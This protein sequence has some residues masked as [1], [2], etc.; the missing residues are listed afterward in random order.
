MINFSV[1]IPAY[2]EE[3][4][5]AS[6]LSNLKEFLKKKFPQQNYEIIVIND[7]STD[8]TEEIIRGIADVKLINHPCN[9]GYGASIKTGILQSKYDIICIMDADGTY[10]A[11]E[12]KQLL[13]YL[14]EYDMAIGARK[15]ED[16]KMS[17]LRRFAKFFLVIL[18]NV[19]TG[20]KIPDINSGLRVFKKSLFKKYIHLLPEG[21]SLTTTITI[22]A[23]TN[24]H[25][26][27]YININYFSRK[28]KSKIRPIRDTYNFI[29]IIL[30]TLL[31][32]NPLK[33][34]L[35]VGIF[36]VFLAIIIGGW[37]ILFLNKFLDTTTLILFMSGLQI[38]ILA[39][40]ADLI[41]NRSKNNDN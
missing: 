29:I 13:T 12:I 27:K 20:T 5:I 2:N 11:T 17:L 41:V 40:L 32:F 36:F 30:R 14:P 18:A 37:S 7:S 23:I 6:T 28:G 9:K 21:F 1:I 4:A 8:K 31:Y 39:L 19:L 26:V 34:L 24:N 22:A 35:P 16:V 38:I 10:P 3:K 25:N 15:G 33:V